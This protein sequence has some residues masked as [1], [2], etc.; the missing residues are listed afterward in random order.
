MISAG[1]PRTGIGTDTPTPTLDPKTTSGLPPDAVAALQAYAMTPSAETAAKAQAALSA[2]GANPDLKTYG[3]D[4]SKMVGASIA[5]QTADTVQLDD[6]MLGQLG[7][8]S[9]EKVQ[10]LAA[11]LGRDP[12]GMTV[13]ELRAAVSGAAASA[14]APLDLAQAMQGDTA[15]GAN[16]R[17]AAGEA[18]RVAAETGLATDAADLAKTVAAVDAAETVEFGGQE[19][20]LKD[21]LS[22]EGMSKVVSDYLNGSDQYKAEFAKAEPE[23]AAWI[24]E[25]STAMQAA[26]KQLGT[27]QGAAEQASASTDAMFAQFE[28]MG[29][30]RDSAQEIVDLVDP[31]WDP[32]SG[33]PPNLEG[34]PLAQAMLDPATSA[35]V[36]PKF[37]ELS[38]LD[39]EIARWLVTVDREEL[40]ARGLLGSMEDPRVER[41]WEQLKEH[42]RDRRDLQSFQ[43]RLDA[44][45]EIPANEIVSAVFGV[46]NREELQSSYSSWLLQRAVDPNIKAPPWV[47][48]VGRS[49]D[50]D[51][52]GILSTGSVFAEKAGTLTANPKEIVAAL[53]AETARS[54]SISTAATQGVSASPMGADHNTRGLAERVSDGKIETEEV[55]YLLKIAKSDAAGS[56]VGR[57]TIEAL[58][59]NPNLEISDT[60]RALL[61]E[62]LKKPAP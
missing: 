16:E 14:S 10:A 26:I 34:S 9:P 60:T 56:D 23:F 32:A 2:A 17:A 20:Q 22:D 21:L 38:N 18:A 15:L 31:D 41:E 25:H 4:P 46:K 12:R 24:D 35:V 27:A 36:A 52:D 37:A 50:P 42:A 28:S 13:G 39:P 7:Y 19:F 53:L 33:R 47:K 59:K 49:L 57:S 8:D 40:E 62:A 11:Q 51:G 43:Q 6:A 55:P 1:V 3:S 58:L 48:L 54:H 30:G 45:E 44:G 29:V 5:G 61:T